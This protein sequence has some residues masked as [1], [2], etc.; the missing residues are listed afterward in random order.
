MDENYEMAAGNEQWNRYMLLFFDFTDEDNDANNC[1][2][3]VEL[4]FSQK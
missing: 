2:E 1:E 4:F 3:G